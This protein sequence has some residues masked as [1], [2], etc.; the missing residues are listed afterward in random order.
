MISALQVTDTSLISA[1][2]LFNLLMQ[3]QY[4]GVQKNCLQVSR[5]F[6]LRAD[7]SL[8]LA[9]QGKQYINSQLLLQL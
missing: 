7:I 2:Q 3:L 4:C 6:R 1:L 8:C 5:G 9:P